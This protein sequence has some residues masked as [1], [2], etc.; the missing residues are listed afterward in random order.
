MKE[1]MNRA[2]QAFASL[3]G[4]ATRRVV[5]IVVHGGRFHA[6]E[7]FACAVRWI[8]NN[9]AGNEVRFVRTRNPRLIASADEVI[10]V[11]R[12]YDPNRHRY[13]HHG[14]DHP[15][16]IR[17]GG[18]PGRA[19]F[20]LVWLHYGDALVTAMIEWMQIPDRLRQ[21]LDITAIANAVDQALVSKVD[22]I[23][24]EGRKAVPG[25]REAFMPDIVSLIQDGMTWRPELVPGVEHPADWIRSQQ[26]EAFCWAVRLAAEAIKAE[27]QKQLANKLAAVAVH[28]MEVEAGG[29]VL[30]GPCYL[31][32][33]QVAAVYPRAKV[34]IFPDHMEG[35]WV[36]F[37]LGR[38]DQL[39]A[40]VPVEWRECAADRQELERV[41]GLGVLHVH[42]NYS[43]HCATIDAA[44][45]V[46]KKLIW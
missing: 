28:E 6:D 44:E 39:R 30:Y 1:L 19:S 16:L 41:V 36:V 10:D 42:E 29:L 45:M 37:I 12:E 21:R 11:G 4:A 9:L 27:I 8:L 43:L 20:G 33:T 34:M 40:E 17:G 7:V 22:L 3:L 14:S 15:D 24:L 32:P 26:H 18:R 23:D 25:G 2:W 13:D 38:R 31:N 5:V 46:A 35:R